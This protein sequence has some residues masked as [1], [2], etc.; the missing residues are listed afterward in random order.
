MAAALGAEAVQRGLQQPVAQL[1]NGSPVASHSFGY[2][3]VCVKPG[4]VLSSL[5]STRSPSTKKST[6]ASPGA[7]HAHERLAREPADLLL[8]RLGI[9]AGTTSSIPPGSYLAA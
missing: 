6:R 5:T 1:G 4:S 2:T 8:H 7:A 9:R 3:L